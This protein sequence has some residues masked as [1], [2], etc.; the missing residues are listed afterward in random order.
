MSRFVDRLEPAHYED[1]RPIGEEIANRLARR[2]G[3]VV[4]PVGNRAPIRGVGEV[5]LA[6]AG[7]SLAS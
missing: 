5:L 2:A 6:A 3:T 4:V 7:G 1:Y